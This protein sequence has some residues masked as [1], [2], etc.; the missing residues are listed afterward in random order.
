M[1]A[2]LLDCQEF[3]RSNPKQAATIVSEGMAARGL[4]V[5]ASAFEVVIRDRLKWTPDLADVEHSLTTISAVAQQ[6]GAIKQAPVFK[7]RQDVLDEAKA[8]R[9]K[10]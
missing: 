4:Q 7:L 8:L 10:A 1:L 5:P 3:I 9:R 2:G 6:L